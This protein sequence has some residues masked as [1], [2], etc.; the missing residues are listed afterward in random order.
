M[1]STLFFDEAD[2]SSALH[3]KATRQRHAEGE[4]ESF[5]VSG[6]PLVTRNAI[7]CFNSGSIPIPSLRA[8][9]LWWLDRNAPRVHLL[10]TSSSPG[11]VSYCC[12]KMSVEVPATRQTIIA[13]GLTHIRE[14]TVFAVTWVTSIPEV[15]LLRLQ[16][17]RSNDHHSQLLL[18]PDGRAVLTS[19]LFR[20][21]EAFENEAET[22][23]YANGGYNKDVGEEV[24]ISASFSACILASLP[25]EKALDGLLSMIILTNGIS[26]WWVEMGEDGAFAEKEIH[27]PN[28]YNGN[29]SG[30]SQGSGVASWLPS[31]PWDG[32]RVK[33]QWCLTV[34]AV[35]QT[36]YILV[37]H[38]SGLLELYDSS[39]ESMGLILSC[40]LP[41]DVI[42][43]S[44]AAYQWATLLNDDIHVVTCFGG[45]EACR[46][47]WLRLPGSMA[48]GNF[49]GAEC[50]SIIPPTDTSTLIGCVALSAENLALLWDFGLEGDACLCPSISI[51]SLL[52]ST[53]QGIS[54]IL[55]LITARPEGN[56]LENGEGG[57]IENC[58]GNNAVALL[59]LKGSEVYFCHSHPLDALTF[60]GNELVLIE[61]MD[62]K[63]RAHVLSDKMSLLEAL[64]ESSFAVGR[65]VTAFTRNSLS[66]SAMHL[67]PAVVRD[68][69]N[70]H[71][72]DTEA[73]EEG[74]ELAASCV[75]GADNLA[76]LLINTVQNV[77]VALTIGG[78]QLLRSA[79]HLQGYVP[80]GL[81][82][83]A[84]MRI[85]LENAA[86]HVEVSFRRNSFCSFSRRFVQHTVSRDLLS[87][88][89]YLVCSYIG[90]M[91]SDL[92]YTAS[93][94]LPRVRIVLEFLSAAYH[95]MSVAGPNVASVVP[96]V[97]ENVISDV[98]QLLLQ[99]KPG[100]GE[101]GED[102][103]YAVQVAKRLWASDGE[104]GMRACVTWCNLLGR[105]Y[106]CLQHFRILRDIGA[107]RT[108]R[109]SHFMT[110]CVTVS[111]HLSSLPAHIAV[112]LLLDSELGICSGGFLHMAFADV[113]VEDWR[114][115]VT[116]N[117]TLVAKLYRVALLRRVIYPRDAHHAIVSGLLIRNLFLTELVELEQYVHLAGGGFLRVHRALVELRL[118]THMFLARVALDEAKID[119]VFRSLEELLQC[120]AAQKT[121]AVYLEQVLSILGEVAELASASQEITD[122]LVS[123]THSNA[124]LDGYLATKW[125]LYAA[126]LSAK[127][128]SL[129]QA[130]VVRLRAARG[131]FRFLCKR[132]AYGQAGRM[133]TD[134]VN[135]V[136]CSAPRSSAVEGVLE[137]SA[138]AVTAV[139][140]IAPDVYL[141]TQQDEREPLTLAAYGPAT[142]PS[143]LDQ[144][145]SKAPLNR[146]HLP[147]LRRRHFQAFCEKRL[148]EVNQYVDCTDL[149]TENPPVE[150]Q[151]AAVR[152]FVSVLMES[153]FWPEARRFAAMMG[154]DVGTVLQGHVL[155]LM[156]STDH[157]TDEEALVEWFEMVEGCE[158]FSSAENQFDPLRRT[159]VAALSCNF[160]KAHPAL[161]ESLEQADRYEALQAL[162]EAFEILHYRRSMVVTANNVANEEENEENLHSASSDSGSNDTISA[163]QP[164]LPLLEA[165][166]IGTSVF[167]DSL[168]NDEDA[169]K[170]SEAPMTAGLFDRMACRARELL[171]SSLLLERL[172]SKQAGSTAEKFL[173]SFEMI[174]ESKLANG[175]VH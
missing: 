125:Y 140:L 32:K 65:P 15:G 54:G 76:A 46:C 127:T 102:A 3:V 99:F 155:D 57:R 56:A 111:F 74:V 77:P 7:H 48:D 30:S 82:D 116:T 58:Q 115:L 134:L 19:R 133:M 162:M 86:T 171:G 117:T 60:V 16:L 5:E 39:V 108:T 157:K 160:E 8:T 118:E 61:K 44:R 23:S 62:E 90:W 93:L 130:E 104:L 27:I 59:P 131:L 91:C 150:V 122:A 25:R 138:L 43:N 129:P 106:P 11:D 41:K 87:R 42:A 101:A 13:C 159:V 67:I 1:L 92:A 173:K 123:L 163:T 78:F 172:S 98:L 170:M 103:L 63:V 35:Q 10:F 28:S 50:M 100:W 75:D 37:L 47:V 95:A 142:Y 88:I 71:C 17:Q 143:V 145:P 21:A 169:S 83:D 2:A 36:Q 40:A 66:L 53:Q 89:A 112:P 148:M 113:T 137:M 29:I 158:E 73:F 18:V 164:W 52:H 153:R 6:G 110:M 126:R 149:W 81:V 105:R 51:G 120:A 20:V 9:L 38:C 152:R 24:G 135:V 136:R 85:A 161:L 132:H 107:G 12:R 124:E 175:V 14:E 4:E 79:A 97:G 114:V 68:E 147:W 174:K 64:I 26:L 96:C 84:A 45:S 151:E 139:E 34:S 154:H 80:S 168:Y 128:A 167:T 165:L 94:E 121:T 69:N 156:T 49:Q 119:D 33:G 141:H 55:H 146:N 72:M 144:T 166:R 109:S 70:P 22:F 31:W